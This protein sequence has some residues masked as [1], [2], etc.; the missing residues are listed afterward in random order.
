[1]TLEEIRK[2]GMQEITYKP[3][4]KDD[5]DIEF[6]LPCGVELY[7]LTICNNEVV[8]APFYLEGL[9]GFLYITHLEELEMIHKMTLEQLFDY[10]EQIH[11]AFDRDSYN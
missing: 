6:P 9:D 5:V 4:W 10:V 8:K 1:M 3:D 2:F 7:C 11:P